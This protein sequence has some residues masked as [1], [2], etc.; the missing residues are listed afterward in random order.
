MIKLI[1]SGL[2]SHSKNS[3]KT[4][5]DFTLAPTIIQNGYL[6]AVADGVGSY[7]GA[8]IASKKAIEVISNIRNKDTIKNKKVTTEKLL[9]EIASISDYDESLYSAATTLTYIYIDSHS[10]TIFHIG[11][12]RAYI[13]LGSKLK[14]LTKDHTQHQKLIDSGAY[15]PNEIK[16]QSLKRT[17]TTAIS[18]TVEPISEIY[19]IDLNT[20]SEDTIDLFIMSDGAHHYWEKRP[21]FSINTLTNANQFSSSLYKRIIRNEIIDDFSLV[22]CNF[23]IF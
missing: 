21:R 2:F 7:K 14:Q 6:F 10:L 3:D 8:N 15:K 11:D 19:T 4:N 22:A 9:N 20:I 23:K 17:L 18:K 5:E 13:R 1:N 12:C 16:D